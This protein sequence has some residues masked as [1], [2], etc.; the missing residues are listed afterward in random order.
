MTTRLHD[1]YLRI[2]DWFQR[3]RS[4]GACLIPFAC[5][6]LSTEKWF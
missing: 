1:L 5:W 3:M 2:P 6:T 4:Y